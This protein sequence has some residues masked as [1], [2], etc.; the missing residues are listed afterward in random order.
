FFYT[1]IWINFHPFG[2]LLVDSLSAMFEIGHQWSESF[3]TSTFCS[4]LTL[5]SKFQYVSLNYYHP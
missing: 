3:F 1:S 5:R 4:D 2:L